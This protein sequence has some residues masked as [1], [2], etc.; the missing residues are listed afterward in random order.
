[1]DILTQDEVKK[2]IKKLQNFES[3]RGDKKRNVIVPEPRVFHL[4][5]NVLPSDNIL[6]LERN[7][8]SCQQICEQLGIKYKGAYE[9][10]DNRL[11]IREWDG[12]IVCGSADLKISGFVVLQALAKLK[13]GRFFAFYQKICFMESYVRYEHVFSEYPFQRLYLTKSR[14][15]VSYEKTYTNS[16][17]R[18]PYG[19]FVWFKDSEQKTPQI[20][21]LDEMWDDYF[22]TGPDGKNIHVN[23]QRVYKKPVNVTIDLGIG[24]HLT[25]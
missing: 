24:K 1:M 15:N 20:Y 16:L 21:W 17:A 22:V 13:P 19:W 7:S 5:F 14:A 4:L 6:E 2:Y 25:P 18:E 11:L 3:G 9:G 10:M 23:Y 12:D 8:N